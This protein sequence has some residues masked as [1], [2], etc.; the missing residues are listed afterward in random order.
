MFTVLN[1]ELS[2]HMENED[3]LMQLK[4]EMNL[5][6]KKYRPDRCLFCNTKNPRFC[7]SH[8]VPRFVLKNIAK[9][10]I[11]FQSS[12]FMHDDETL[13]DEEKGLNNTGTFRNICT[14][15]DKEVFADY[16]D[17]LKLIEMPSNEIMLQIAI[18]NNL[19][20]I[21]KKYI[22]KGIYDWAHEKLGVEL[23]LEEY[24]GLDLYEIRKKL[25]NYKKAYYK[26]KNV[27]FDL[28]FWE[29]L[30][31][32]VPY[33]FQGEIT[34]K[35][36]LLGFKVNDVYDSDLRNLIQCINVCVFPLDNC[37]VV[38][39]FRDRSYRK[40]DNFVIQFQKRD[41][42]E[43]LYIINYMIMCFSED[44]YISKH[45]CKEVLEN[46]NIKRICSSYHLVRADVHGD[47]HPEDLKAVYSLLRDML[48]I[49]NLLS[50][51]YKIR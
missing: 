48:E 12:L 23:P 27:E 43:Q 9:N 14:K 5:A 10:G 18:K 13:M 25:N 19:F 21:N 24:H 36:D 38:M 16:E 1:Y 47:I 28:F 44:Y 33:A 20:E 41:L 26:K 42:R 11:I 45:I 40:L 50:Q 6:F 29:K 3:T 37:S 30:E 15:C 7:N 22:E 35:G 32:V 17:K 31:Y 2:V 49:P 39:A 8:S 46:A 51:E 34:L 4:K